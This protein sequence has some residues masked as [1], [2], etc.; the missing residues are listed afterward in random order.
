[1]PLIDRRVIINF[2]YALFI[3]AIVICLIGVLTIHSA[4]M[5]SETSKHLYI[6]QLIWMGLGLIILFIVIAVDYHRWLRY[7]N[8]FYLGSILL[9]IYLILTPNQSGEVRRYLK[10]FFLPKFIPSE[11]LKIA[12]VIQLA[13]YFRERDLKDLCFKE[14]I[15]PS[16][17]IGIPL[18]LIML[19]P[20]LGTAILLIPLLGLIL[21]LTGY[22]LKKL[23]LI[24]CILGI[25]GLFAADKVLK[26]YQKQRLTAFLHQ[27]SNL[28]GAGYQ[29]DQSKLA[30]GSGGFLGKGW[31]KGPLSHLHYLPEQHTDFIFSVFAEE[32]GFLGCL[33][34]IGLYLFFI[35]RGIKIAGSAVDASGAILAAGLVMLIALQALINIGMVIGMLPITGLPLPFMSYGGSPFF[36]YMISLGLI[37][38]VKMREFPPYR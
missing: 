4:V 35:H 24:G 6:K 22:D 12:V 30:I 33:F 38:N 34:L 26:D 17:I 5:A 36:T 14:I 21:Y 25:V 7:H 31:K 19:Q 8:I 20:D 10:F 37:L 18:I 1:M 11:F 3:S 27:G 29:L 15:P 16:L 13:W 9:L 2:D 28:R 32:R 23:L